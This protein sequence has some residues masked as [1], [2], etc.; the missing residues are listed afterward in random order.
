MDKIRFRRLSNGD[1]VVPNRGVPPPAPEGYFQD[2]H[3]AHIYHPLT[4]NCKHRFTIVHN[5]P[6]C[7]CTYIR[8]VCKLDN[9]VITPEKCEECK[10]ESK[11]N[12]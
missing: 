7:S 12:R 9:E 1:L 5:K 8:H 3:Y 10:D 4:F 2:L 6:S 11:T